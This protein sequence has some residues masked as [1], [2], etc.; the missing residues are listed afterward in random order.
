MA[1]LGMVHQDLELA[2]ALCEP[3]SKERFGVVDAAPT[4]TPAP[5]RDAIRARAEILVLRAV[6]SAE[7]A[8]G[9]CAA[10]VMCLELDRVCTFI[11]LVLSSSID[12]TVRLPV[13]PTF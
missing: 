6:L 10:N 8:C 1:A 9:A 5:L 13:T 11:D 4:P 2:A 3:P 7:M 12:H